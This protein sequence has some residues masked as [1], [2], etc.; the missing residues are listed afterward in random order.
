MRGALVLLSSGC[1]LGSPDSCGG[2]PIGVAIPSLTASGASCPTAIPADMLVVSYRG[3][4][5]CP[6][7]CDCGEHAQTNLMTACT[8]GITIDCALPD[9]SLTIH[10]QLS[11]DVWESGERAS[12]ACTATLLDRAGVEQ[13]AGSGS[14]SCDS[15]IGIRC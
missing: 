4:V 15:T 5:A 8:S 9:A 6:I 13:C 7:G 11:S 10:C 2:P 1:H 14:S 12:L 3:E